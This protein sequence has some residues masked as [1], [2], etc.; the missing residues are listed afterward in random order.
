MKRDTPA[1]NNNNNS[2]GSSSTA[3]T[4]YR[5]LLYCRNT[6]EDLEYRKKKVYKQNAYIHAL[7]HAHWNS[8]INIVLLKSH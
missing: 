2:S 7:I 1:N 3:T 6:K 4:L 8:D 5:R